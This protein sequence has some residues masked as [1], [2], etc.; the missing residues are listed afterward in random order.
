MSQADHPIPR[1]FLEGNRVTTWPIQSDDPFTSSSTLP[2]APIIPFNVP[3]TAMSTLVSSSTTLPSEAT[4]LD[5]FSRP[6]DAATPSPTSLLLS[7]LL[8]LGFDPASYGTLHPGLLLDAEM[9]SRNQGNARAFE[10][11]AAWLWE[12][13]EGDDAK[14]L[15]SSVYPCTS[16]ATSREFRNLIFGWFS[17]LKK[18]GKL[19][20]PGSGPNR[21]SAVLDKDGNSGAVFGEVVVRRS[22]LDECRG[23][24]FER[25]ML[26]VSEVVVEQTAAKEIGPNSISGIPDLRALK[27]AM[28]DV[29][30]RDLLE[31]S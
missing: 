12:R 27:R 24:R 7:N 29:A 2:Q 11:V 31:V 4:V 26:A 25:L 17:Q 1:S 23:E 21:T 22:F 30:I 8:L 3:P 13:S 14:R 20:G 10:V 18:D 9:F 28:G 6:C 19:S 5:A 16:P 15:L